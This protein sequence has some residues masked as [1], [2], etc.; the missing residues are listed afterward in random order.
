MQVRLLSVALSYLLTLR[1]GTTPPVVL[2]SLPS[3]L[4]TCSAESSGPWIARRR[5]RRCLLIDDL[6]AGRRQR[7]SDL[8]PSTLARVSTNGD[9]DVT[10]TATNDARDQLCDA[11]EATFQLDRRLGRIRRIWPDANSDRLRI[12]HARSWRLGRRR[13]GT[14]AAGIKAARSASE[15]EATAT[16]EHHIER[17]ADASAHGELDQA[18]AEAVFAI[19]SIHDISIPRLTLLFAFKHSLD[20]RVDLQR[21]LLEFMT[22]QG[23]G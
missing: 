20:F 10:T 9:D 15:S 4:R 21:R 23:T 2:G 14:G 3:H 16:A 19:T 17:E 18:L 12:R 13:A 1:N 22:P 7:L 11:D 5:R 8:F 6:D